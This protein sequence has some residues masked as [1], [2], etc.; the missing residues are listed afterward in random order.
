M[1]AAVLL[2][3]G[4]EYEAPLVTEPTIPIDA[5]FLGLWK[6][7]PEEGVAP[8]EDARLIVARYSDTEYLI[9]Y[10][11][12]D[13]GIYYRGYP[14]Q[15][16]SKA[17]VQLEAIGTAEGPVDADEKGLFHVVSYAIT[18]GTL[19]VWLL[20]EKVVSDDYKTSEELRAVFLENIDHPDLFKDAVG[21]F[22]RARREEEK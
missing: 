10:P 2:I 3:A 15:I 8:E 9:H 7:V 13:E 12:N 14:I 22:Q 17:C 19:D 1:A 21:R 18:N 6:L 16:G 11:T 5:E 20:N 4:C